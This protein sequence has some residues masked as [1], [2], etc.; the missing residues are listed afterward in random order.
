MSE[1]EISSDPS[2]TTQR[3]RPLRRTIRGP[4]VSIVVTDDLIKTSEVRSSSHCMIAEA[5]RASVPNAQKITVDLQTVRWSD[6]TKGLRYIYLTP[7]T[8]Q[9]A[10]INF[11]QG[12]RPDAFEFRLRGAQVTRMGAANKAKSRARHKPATDIKDDHQVDPLKKK[13]VNAI[14]KLNTH[15]TGGLPPPVSNFAKRR[16]FGI[17]GLTR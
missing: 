5:V 14:G 12:E 11:D 10:L 13:S 16:Q 4:V 2:T 3:L 7:R 15:V 1:N 9:V 8:A 17:K 6:A